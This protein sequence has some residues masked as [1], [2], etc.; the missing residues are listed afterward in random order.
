MQARQEAR[1][2]APF[3][4]KLGKTPKQRRRTGTEEDG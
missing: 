4:N 3:S 1:E 2:S